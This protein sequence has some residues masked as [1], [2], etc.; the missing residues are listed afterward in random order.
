MERVN[1][2]PCFKVMHRFGGAAH[3]S[4]EPGQIRTRAPML[5]VSPGLG[6]GADGG[7]TW[8]PCIQTEQGEWVRGGG[9]TAHG[10]KGV[11]EGM[12]SGCHMPSSCTVLPNTDLDPRSGP[13]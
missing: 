5:W 2:S 8:K 12:C 13:G 4:E 7:T 3:S 9:Q 6:G 1:F 11:G 10:W